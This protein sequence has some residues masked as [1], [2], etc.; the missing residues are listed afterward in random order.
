MKLLASRVER[1]Q[2]DIRLLY[3]LCGFETAADGLRLVEETYPEYVIPP[4]TRFMLEEMFPDR[5]I[6]RDRGRRSEGPGIGF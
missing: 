2:D 6:E 3:G 1:D 5:V 4:K